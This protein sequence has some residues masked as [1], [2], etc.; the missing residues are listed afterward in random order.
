MGRRAVVQHDAR[1]DRQPR[2]Q[3]VPHHPAGRAEP[4]E[5]IGGPEVVVQRVDLQVLEQDA[6]VAVDDRLRQPGRARAVED[7]ERMVERDLLEAQRPRLGA[8]ARPRSIASGNGRRARIGG[9]GATT[10]ARRLG[11]AARMA[12]TSSAR[13]TVA[14]AVA[15]AVDGEE[16][17]RLDLAE[18][19][20]HAAHAELGRAARPDRAQRGRGQQRDERLR[21]VRQVRGHPVAA[22]HAEA[23]EPGAGARDLRRAAR[24]AVE[25]QPLPSL[26]A[27]DDHDVRSDRGPRR[28]RACSAQFRPASGN[29]RAPGMR[30]SAERRPRPASTSG[31]SK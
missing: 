26:R 8:A 12:A 14:V 27:R 24:P 19:I 28:R 23:L 10:V 7:V 29:Q 31:R 22:A 21:H 15:I 25:R 4:E 11:S 16:H 13:S 2:D 17:L 5:P 1:V 20:D 3:V 30:S 9:R 6:A 18:A